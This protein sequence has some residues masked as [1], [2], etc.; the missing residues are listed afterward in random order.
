MPCDKIKHIKTSDESPRIP[1]EDASVDHVHSS[2]VLMYVPDVAATLRELRRIL[3][4]GG[5]GR[6]MVYNYD[7][8]WFHLFAGYVRRLT[9]PE[10]AGKSTI[11]AFFESTDWT[12]CP[13]N[14]VWKPEQFIEIAESVGFQCQH[15]GNAVAVREIEILPRRF[16]AILDQRL[17]PEHRKFLLGFTYDE[18]GVPF[19]H[20]NAAGIDG[21]YALQLRDGFG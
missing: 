15:V 16:E 21:C 17:E 8:I 6:I 9:E 14:R 7:C 11:E 18:R 1:L 19:Y 5:S 10:Y 2:S 3:K 20:G 4:P 12:N 13:V